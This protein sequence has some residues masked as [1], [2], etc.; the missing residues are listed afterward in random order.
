MEIPVIM[1]G[2]KDNELNHQD[3][4]FKELSEIFYS[5]MAN[6]TFGIEVLKPEVLD[7]SIDSLDH[8]NEYLIKIRDKSG[9]NKIW[10]KVIL[11]C[12]AYVGEV[13]RRNSLKSEYHWL[14]YEN[15][16]KKENKFFNQLDYSIGTAA[17][18]Y[19]ESGMFCF[20]LGKVE[21]FLEQGPEH[22]IKI[23]VQA[24]IDQ[25]G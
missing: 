10:N 14:D 24:M 25:Q 11:R 1:S 2:M 9:I 3:Q 7:Y 17:V 5:D 8:I 20:P 13:I 19:A 21:K 12:G 6:P 22:N 15:A 23:F 16:R 18:L 4:E